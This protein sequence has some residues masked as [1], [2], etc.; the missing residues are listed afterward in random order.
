M[1]FSAPFSRVITRPFGGVPATAATGWWLS[2]G[3]AAANCI[4]A[5][6]PKGAASIEASL[7]NLNNP[8]TNNATAPAGNPTFD[9]SYGWAGGSSK[10]LSTG[11]VVDDKAHSVFVR[12]SDAPAANTEIIGTFD[13][14]NTKALYIR[15]NNAG[16][17]LVFYYA[18]TN[19]VSLTGITSGVIG[20]AGPDTYS[21]GSD[22]GTLTQDG[23]SGGQYPLF[24]FAINLNGSPGQYYTGKIQAFAM[25]DSTLTPAQVS[26]LTTAMA[27]L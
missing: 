8:G 4:A 14:T 15:P 2:G 25:Y 26:A 23:T 18:S 11:Y 9:T 20:V 22:V 10:Y 13:A 3:I 6:Q 19:S 27:A 1:T 7:V 16:D 17:D 24:I 12:F 5:Y 21:N